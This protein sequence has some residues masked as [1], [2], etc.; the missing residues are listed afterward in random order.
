MR[1]LF[2]LPPF[3]GRPLFPVPQAPELFIHSNSLSQ[4]SAGAF[5]DVSTGKVAIDPQTRMLQWKESPT[6]FR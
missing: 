5:A 2:S 1:T 4:A 6:P 3:P